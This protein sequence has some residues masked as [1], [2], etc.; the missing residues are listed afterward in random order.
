MGY[1]IGLDGIWD[2]VLCCAVLCRMISLTIGIGSDR[3][4][5]DL[6]LCLSLSLSFIDLEEEKKKN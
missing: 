3:I 1:G 6:A 4:G 2:L 5:S